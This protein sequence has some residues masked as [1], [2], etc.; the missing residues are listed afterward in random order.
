MTSGSRWKSAFVRV[1]ILGWVEQAESNA[2]GWDVDPSS[3]RFTP[4]TCALLEEKWGAR[5]AVYMRRR[6]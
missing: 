1:R 6:S 2:F 3:V 4:L 5:Y